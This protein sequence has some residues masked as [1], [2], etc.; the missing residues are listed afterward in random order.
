M[1]KFISIQ[2]GDTIITYELANFFESVNW[3]KP[4][5][6]SIWNTDQWNDFYKETKKLHKELFLEEEYIID[7]EME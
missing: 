7:Y 1:S 3:D 5:D 2:E 6:G 4:Q